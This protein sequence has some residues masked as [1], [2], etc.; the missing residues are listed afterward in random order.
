MRH[1]LLLSATAFKRDLSDCKTIAD[2]VG[3]VQSVDRLRQLTLLTIVDIR[4][5]GPGT[6]NSWKRQLIGELYGAAEERLRLGH[7]EFGRGKR[8]AAKKAAVVGADA[9]SGR[10][11]SRRSAAQPSSMPTGSPKPRT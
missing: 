6:W 8:V 4:A 1:H 5:V 11:W 2:F 9:R 3:V 10:R 7:A